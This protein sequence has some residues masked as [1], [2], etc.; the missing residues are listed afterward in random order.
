MN[1]SEAGR[2][3]NAARWAGTTPD[4][5]AEATRAAKEAALKSQVARWESEVD[6]DRVLDPAERARRVAA[7]KSEYYA[8]LARRAAAARQARAAEQSSEAA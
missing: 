1:A 4:E 2:A 5:R 6:P 3:L 8:W 7:A